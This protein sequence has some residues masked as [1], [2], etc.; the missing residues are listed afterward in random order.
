MLVTDG[1]ETTLLREVPNCVIQAKSDL[2]IDAGSRVLQIIPTHRV[3]S[4]TYC[5]YYG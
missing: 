1:D 5:C 4:G 3:H 2:N